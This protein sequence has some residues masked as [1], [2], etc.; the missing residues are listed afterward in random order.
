[1]AKGYSIVFYQSCFKS[2][3]TAVK[4]FEAGI[5]EPV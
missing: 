3:G 2:C 1:M 5:K 4:V